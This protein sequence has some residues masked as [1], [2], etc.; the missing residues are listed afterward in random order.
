MAVSD[1]RHTRPR[2]TSVTTCQDWRA[3][4]APWQVA[5]TSAG[6]R[7]PSAAL[8]HSAPDE[9]V[10][11]PGAGVSGVSLSPEVRRAGPNGRARPPLLRGSI[12]PLTNAYGGSSVGINAFEN[13]APRETVTVRLL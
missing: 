12:R 8:E 3:S 1:A 6:S 11:A 5:A 10:L 9:V 13:L 2:L 4:P 7:V